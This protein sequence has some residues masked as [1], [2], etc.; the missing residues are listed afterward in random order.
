MNYFELFE[1]PV[2]FFPD[3]AEIRKKYHQL[4]FKF[5][6]DFHSVGSAYTENEVLEK[7]TEI[8]EAYQTLLDHDKLLSYILDLYNALPQEGQA[9]VPQDFLLDMMDINEELMELEMEPDP[10]KHHS[11][12]TKV[13]ELENQITEEVKSD[14]ENFDFQHAEVGTLKKITDFYLKKQYILRLKQNLSNFA[15]P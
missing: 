8:N 6:P 11:L 15:S 7:S 14:M 1:V 5:H 12:L 13:T 9:K 4:S 2:S 10:T 3:L